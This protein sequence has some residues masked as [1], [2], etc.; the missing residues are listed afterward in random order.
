MLQTIINLCLLLSQGSSYH[1]TCAK[2][3]DV[4]EAVEVKMAQARPMLVPHSKRPLPEESKKPKPLSA[5]KVATAPG[6]ENTSR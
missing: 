5:G 1:L 2:L 3:E 4:S 6:K